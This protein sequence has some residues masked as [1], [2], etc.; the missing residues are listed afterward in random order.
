MHGVTQ[1]RSREFPATRIAV[2][3]SIARNDPVQST[4]NELCRQIER[5]VPGAIAGVCVLDRAARVFEDAFFPSLAPTF[6]E[7]IR[8]ARVVER[9]G[10]CALAI[11]NGVVVTSTDIG[12]DK[13]FRDEWCG[14]NLR[15]EIRSIQSRPVFSP[16]HT[17]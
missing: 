9:P 14:L 15:H 13:R 7:G 11:Y 5:L 3:E 4:L 16:D 10:S 6:A 8:G 2:L 17:A 12:A 1:D